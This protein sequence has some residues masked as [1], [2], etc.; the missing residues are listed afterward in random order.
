MSVLFM[1]RS[2]G[3]GGKTIY[4]DAKEAI[5]IRSMKHLIAFT[6]KYYRG[7]KKN[8]V[9][10]VEPIG[11]YDERIDWYKFAV[12]LDNNYIG[13]LNSTFS[14]ARIKDVKNFEL[15]VGSR[16]SIAV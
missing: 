4:D 13:C 10:K 9:L 12:L 8:S 7:W 11:Y 2:I 3:S 15:I 5:K 14:K 16:L 1:P 6:K